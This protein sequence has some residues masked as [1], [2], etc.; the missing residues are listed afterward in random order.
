MRGEEEMTTTRMGWLASALALIGLAAFASPAVGAFGAPVDVS[1]T[2]QNPYVATDADGDA[3]LTWEFGAS[4]STNR[5]QAR[6]LSAAGA[7]GTVHELGQTSGTTDRFARVATDRSGDSVFAWTRFD[8]FDA[9]LAR[10]L[11]ATG[12]LGGIIQLSRGGDPGPFSAPEVATDRNGDTVFTWVN[13]S[14]FGDPRVQA[15]TL[16]ASGA[17]GPIRN[18]SPADEIGS[19]PQVATDRSG[20]SVL[21]WVREDGVDGDADI[22]QARQMSVNGSLGPIKD[23]SVPAGRAFAPQ[24]ASDEDGDVVF[25]WL[26]FDGNRDRAQGRTMTSAGAL[27]T[28]FVLTPSGPSARDPQVA[29]DAN[30]DAV[31]TWQ[32][33]EVDSDRIQSRTRSAAGTLG[34][35][36]N[37]SAAGGDA[38]APQVASRDDGSSV[39]VWLRFDGAND[40][41]QARTMTA[42]GALGTVQTISDA[43]ADALTPQV[44]IGSTSGPA[45]ATWERA[46]VVQASRGP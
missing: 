33:F 32:R 3:A 14:G 17:L 2:A 26:R 36:T 15:R 45:V 42:G 44:A 7:L 29:I 35:I 10:R 39:F 28:T 12:T 37:L 18:V 30:G 19:Q 22:V 38:Y 16:T 34:A 20:D 27:G 23:L 9:V 31:F 41:V 24:V 1:T 4:L 6:T 43:G 8:P 21:T 46:D 11:S 5:V 25:T 13:D 40:R